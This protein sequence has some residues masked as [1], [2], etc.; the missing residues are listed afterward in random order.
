VANGIELRRIWPEI[1]S[2]PNPFIYVV[3]G[4]SLKQYGDCL[5][6]YEDAGVDLTQE[7]VVGLGSVCR[8]QASREIADIVD[9]LWPLKL[10]GFGVKQQGL[11]QYKDKLVSSDSMAWSYDA[12]KKW[13]LPGHQ[14]RHINCANC[15]TYAIRWREQLIT[16]RRD[17]LPEWGP[18]G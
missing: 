16:G 18:Y 5:N 12:R 8:R 9:M 1:T 14:Y 11:E 4:D 13:P 15:I 6:M 3:Q 7:K 2:L 17:L 10:H